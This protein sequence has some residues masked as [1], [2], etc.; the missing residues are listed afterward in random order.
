MFDSS[1]VTSEG[2]EVS[3]AQ[4]QLFRS[5]SGALGRD[6]DDAGYAW[7]LDQ[8]AIG[9]HDLRSMAAGF[10]FSEEFTGFFDAPD[11][12]SIDNADFVNHMYVNVFGREPDQGGFDFWFG[13]LESGSRTQVDVLVDMT[14]SNEYVQLTVYSAVDY[15]IG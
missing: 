2:F 9:N 12:N 11:G 4:A 8:I 10:I 5:Y 15:I 14:Q 1:L 6:P 13:E 3:T 7:W